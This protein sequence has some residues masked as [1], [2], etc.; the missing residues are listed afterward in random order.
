MAPS[1]P[2]P[3]LVRYELRG[4]V[5]ILTMDNPPVNVVT[6]GVL[7][8]LVARL[9]EVEAEPLA[10]VVVLASAS[11]KAFGAG[12]NI[13]EMADLGPSEAKRHGS[14]GQAATVALERL[15][16]PVIAAVNGSALGGGCEL[17]LACDL[18]IASEDARFG[19]PEINLG[20]MPGWGGTQRLPRWIGPSQARYWIM[21]GRSVSAKEAEAMGLVL[22]VVPPAELLSSA[23]SLA[24]ELAGKSATALAAA[25]FAVNHAIAPGADAALAFELE[26]WHGLFATP[27][28]KEG[29][30]AFLEKRSWTPATRHRA[31]P[32]GKAKN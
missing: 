5:A 31:E 19:Q 12:A 28:Q 18:V 22:K 29:M 27:D 13:K 14:R 3:E 6:A 4:P 24:E 10:R 15:P 23:L 9:A 26:L 2:A 11:S 8:R 30:K 32:G 1:T 20:L 21:T 25:K 7:E 17:A 16:M